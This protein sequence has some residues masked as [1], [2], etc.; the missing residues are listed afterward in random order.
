[1]HADA[2]PQRDVNSVCEKILFDLGLRGE[3][4]QAYD[5]LL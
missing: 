3:L 4:Q 2:T 5:F 1:L